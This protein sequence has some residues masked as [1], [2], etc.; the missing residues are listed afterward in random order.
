MN[1]KSCLNIKK[2]LLLSLLF[3][4]VL[5]FASSASYADPVKDVSSSDKNNGIQTGLLKLKLPDG[6]RRV[7]AQEF[8]KWANEKKPP[9]RTFA[10]CLLLSLIGVG[11]FPELIEKAKA[12]CRSEFWRCFGRAFL[13]NICLLVLFRAFLETKVTLPASILFVGFFELLLMAGLAV[14]ICLIG[15]GIAT[16]SGIT[17]IEAIKRRP[18]LSAFVIVFIGCFLITLLTQIPGIG[19]LP[20]IGVRLAILIAAL[21]EGGLITIF[22]NR[23]KVE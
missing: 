21:G 1:K 12:A 2:I 13:L 22:L 10:L 6:E 23:N 16:K 3:F 18:K 20:P 14:S 19:Q 11:F 8:R 17:K 9:A 7:A 5:T 15:E 4:A